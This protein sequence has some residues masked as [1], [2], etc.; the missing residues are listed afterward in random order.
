MVVQCNMI[1][2]G[3]TYT[4]KLSPLHNKL[5]VTYIPN[6]LSYYKC[7]MDPTVHNLYYNTF[8]DTYL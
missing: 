3:C 1:V 7:P 5:H 2:H 8:A 6:S 4:T